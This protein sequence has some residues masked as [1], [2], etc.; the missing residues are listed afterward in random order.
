M[1]L[2]GKR[3][4][5]EEVTMISTNEHLTMASVGGLAAAVLGAAIGGSLFG[6]PGLLVAALIGRVGATIF[7]SFMQEARPRRAR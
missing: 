3:R 4:E 5:Q 2:C 1:P 7:G 6:L